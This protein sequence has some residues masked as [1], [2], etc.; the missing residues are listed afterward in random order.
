[1][2]KMIANNMMSKTLVDLC[3]ASLPLIDLNPI[4]MHKVPAII[5]MIPNSKKGEYQNINDLSARF[6]DSIT[7]KI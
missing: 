6:D 2:T 3:A 4:T 7:V 5:N 1:M